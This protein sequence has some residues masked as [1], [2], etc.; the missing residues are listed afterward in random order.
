MILILKGHTTR[1][2]LL[3]SMHSKVKAKE[4]DKHGGTYTHDKNI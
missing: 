2:E 4:I 3:V 1:N